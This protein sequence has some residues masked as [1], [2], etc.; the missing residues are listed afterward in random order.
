MYGGRCTKAAVS[1]HLAFDMYGGRCK[2]PMWVLA[3]FADDILLAAV[4]DTDASSRLRIQKF[5][6]HHAAAPYCCNTLAP[7]HFT[8]KITLFASNQTPNAPNLQNGI[9]NT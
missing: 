5:A 8:T 7:I 4:H 3:R 9:S 6:L 2:R 1:T